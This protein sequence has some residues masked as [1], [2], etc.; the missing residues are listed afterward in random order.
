M[1]P[2]LLKAI[3]QYTFDQ[4][5]LSAF[6]LNGREPVKGDYGAVLCGMAVIYLPLTGP[7]P[8]NNFATKAID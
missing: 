5:P 6:S 4:L 1:N 2:R 8:F 3:G 7:W